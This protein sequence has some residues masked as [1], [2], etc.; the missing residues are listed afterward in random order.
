MGFPRQEYWSGLPFPSPG[1]LPSPEIDPGSPALQV[2]SLPCEPKD[3]QR[4]IQNSSQA[5]EGKVVTDEVTEAYREKTTSPWV[6][7]TDHLLLDQDAVQVLADQVFYTLRGTIH[8][9]SQ[10]LPS[11]LSCYKGLKKIQIARI[12]DLRTKPCKA[13]GWFSRQ[14]EAR[15]HLQS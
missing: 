12:K 3:L 1:N 14:A 13:S 6:S 8:V 10:H 11:S 4:L 7:A 15:I 2:D 9:G 5:P